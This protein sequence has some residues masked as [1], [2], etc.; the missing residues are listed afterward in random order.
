[1][2]TNGGAVV[3]TVEALEK[4]LVFCELSP[5]MF[6]SAN[7]NVVLDKQ[8][9]VVKVLSPQHSFSP[10]LSCWVFSPDSFVKLCRALSEQEIKEFP[11]TSRELKLLLQ[12]C[13]K[14]A[15]KGLRL[16]VVGTKETISHQNVAFQCCRVLDILQRKIRPI[17]I[18]NLLKQ[19]IKVLQSMEVDFT[20]FNCSHDF[21]AVLILNKQISV[22]SY[23]PGVF[24]STGYTGNRLFRVYTGFWKAS[25]ENGFFA[26]KKGFK[27][28]P[29]SAWKGT[30]IASLF[31][32]F[33]NEYDF[34]SLYAPVSEPVV[35]AL[36]QVVNSYNLNAE[37]P[38]ES[39]IRALDTVTTATAFLEKSQRWSIYEQ[40]SL[41][42]ENWLQW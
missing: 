30:D 11:E 1:M 13:A 37:I 8:K 2:V 28:P 15:K 6:S 25:C 19:T 7:T 24:I 22:E 32:A 18:T 21:V 29:A 42:L 41:L 10:N 17:Y 4:S 27:F 3:A 20:L 5:E 9:S 39:I 36:K 38:T 33:L 16:Q 35:C 26:L 40:V 14:R 23:S 34:A 12:S 31:V